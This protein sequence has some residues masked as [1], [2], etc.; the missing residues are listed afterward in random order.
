MI[1]T[2]SWKSSCEN[3][4]HDSACASNNFIPSALI[5]SRFRERERKHF[6]KDHISHRSGSLS[7]LADTLA[8]PQ[9]QSLLL[10]RLAYH[11]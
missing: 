8:A 3:L 11:A 9:L 10:P 4:Q 5:V 7:G 2:G 1:H 6:E